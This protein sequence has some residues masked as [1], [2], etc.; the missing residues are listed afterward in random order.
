M[1]RANYQDKGKRI[2]DDV[3][4][5]LTL[6]LSGFGASS[7]KPKILNHSSSMANGEHSGYNNSN[8]NVNDFQFSV[9][10]P[11]SLPMETE[12]EWRKMNDPFSIMKTSSLPMESEMQWRQSN[13]P[14]S[15]TRTSSSPMETEMEYWRQRN[16]PFSVTRTSSLPMETEMEYWRQRNN[17]YSVTRTSSLPMETEIDWRQRNDP[18]S[19]M[20]MYSLPMESEVEWRQRM[21]TEMDWRQR[22]ETEIEWRRRM[23]TEMEYWRQMNDPFS[24]IKTASLPPMETEIEW[25]QRSDPFSVNRTASL[26]PMKTEEEWMQSNDPF[27]TMRTASLPPMET[28][29]DWKERRDL[30]TQMRRDAKQKRW[31]KLKNVIV[32]EENEVNET[33]SLPSSGGSGSQGS[34]GSSETGFETP[35]QLPNQ[36]NGTSIAGASGSSNAIPPASGT[37]EQMQHLI[38]AAIE[39]TNEQSPDFSGKEG[40]RNFLLKMPGVSTK[41]DGSNGKKTEGFLYAYK[42]GGEVKIV[43]ICHGHFLTPAEFVKHAGGGDVENP[44]KLITIDPN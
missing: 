23:E 39:A 33:S 16:D 43:C 15:V 31:D 8:R 14:F 18:Y 36:V 7:K 25:M 41:G 35:Q 13:D 9:I 27:S 38:V 22:M 19:I 2:V 44:L 17:P 24:I 12:A 28:E 10:R 29:M 30:Q 1:E 3:S 20:K 26:P 40:L 21:E 32:V 42:K 37:L 4:V 34:V 6:G 5:E 11:A